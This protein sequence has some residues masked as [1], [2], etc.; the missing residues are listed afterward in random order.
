MTNSFLVNLAFSVPPFLFAIIL[1][2]VAHGYVAFKLGDPTAKALGRITLN[3]LRHIDMFMSIILPGLL[4]LSHSPIIFGG[5][6]PVP[7]NPGY[8]KNPKRDMALVAAAGPI[9]NFIIA[10]LAFQLSL[11]LPNNESG[12]F[13]SLL[14]PIWLIYSII[15]N[16]ALG[17][18]NLLPIPPLDGGRIMVGILP[19]HLAKKWAKLERFGIL[20]VF[21]LLMLDIPQKV[22]GPAI[23]FVSQELVEKLGGLES[24][25]EDRPVPEILSAPKEGMPNLQPKKSKEVMPGLELT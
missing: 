2:E 25:D 13:F 8:F 24:A 16:V 11:T 4:I 3:P 18:F 5:A 20:I 23:N 9:I 15:I 14:I 1:H 19:T 6:K 10:Y 17:L 22:L 21:L 12:S 7:V